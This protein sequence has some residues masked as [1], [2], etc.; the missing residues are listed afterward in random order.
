MRHATHTTALRLLAVQERFPQLQALNFSEDEPR[1]LHVSEVTSGY[2][3]V[4]VCDSSVQ[5][6]EHEFFLFDQHPVVFH[7]R[8]REK[9]VLE[10]ELFVHV[11]DGIDTRW[12]VADDGL[13]ARL[14]E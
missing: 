9:L 1:V 4:V 6:A 8:D 3:R 14:L 7:G 11:A 13:R 2:A 12:A 10:T 5:L